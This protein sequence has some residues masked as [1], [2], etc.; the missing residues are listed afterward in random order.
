[1]KT[2]I[3]P[4]PI[5]RI[6]EDAAKTFAAVPCDDTLCFGV[7]D[8][9]MEQIQ[10][11][12]ILAQGK[13]I[14]YQSELLYEGNMP[15][16]NEEYVDKLRLFDEVW[17]YS[18]HN[19][20]YLR[21]HGLPCV[22][23]KPLRPNAVLKDP[24]KEKDIDLLHYGTWSRHRTDYLNFVIGQ[25][26]KVYDVLRENKGLIYGDDLHQLVLR[27]KVVLGLHSYPQSSIQESFR[28]QYPLSND[29]FVLAEKSLS[30][31]LCLDEFANEEDLARY[32]SKLG[33]KRVDSSSY[34]ME[35]Y[36]FPNYRSYQDEAF[37]H[38]STKQLRDVLDYALN[39][40][41]IDA[42][43]VK[44]M[45]FVACRKEDVRMMSLKLFDALLWQVSS[46]KKTNVFDKV[47]KKKAFSHMR[48]VYNALQKKYIKGKLASTGGFFMP[49]LRCGLMLNGWMLFAISIG[50]AIRFGKENKYLRYL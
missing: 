21:Q 42:V 38:T 23:Y 13:L 14:A 30:N 12:R 41:C 8:W 26:Y 25:G 4:I 37:R 36:F 49:R 11:Q 44:K 7:Q 3:L 10:E 35:N 45:R 31:P 27:S 18:E 6:F 24:P 5:H 1:M 2:V 48:D 19:L 39:K 17:D 16:R 50:I 34:L 20:D 9:T 28:Y 43:V 22:V 40:M 15:F 46:V 29:I 33:L 32:L 47:E